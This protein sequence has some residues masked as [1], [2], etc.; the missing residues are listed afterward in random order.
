MASESSTTATSSTST[1]PAT[2]LWQ[3]LAYLLA[4]LAMNRAAR[5]IRER[6]DALA[7]IPVGDDAAMARH[8]EKTTAARTAA[9][10][11]LAGLNLAAPRDQ[12]AAHLTDA[13]TWSDSSPIARNAL[14]RLVAC[15]D[16]EFGIKIDPSGRTM[17]LDP[18][19]PGHEVQTAIEEDA[20]WLRHKSAAHAVTTLIAATS[21]SPPA[22]AEVTDIVN[23]W[24][25]TTPTNS[26][27]MDSAAL[28][29]EAITR[30]RDELAT[31][32]A[33]TALDE[34]DR[35][36]ALFM[37]DYLTDGHDHPRA[38]DLLDTPAVF[39][40]TIAPPPPRTAP[41]PEG[42]HRGPSPAPP[43]V[44]PYQDQSQG[45]TLNTATA[46]TSAQGGPSDSAAADPNSPPPHHDN[47]GDGGGTPDQRP[48]TGQP[49]AAGSQSTPP[50]AASA[51]PSAAPSDHLQPESTQSTAAVDRPELSKQLRKFADNVVALHQLAERFAD[52]PGLAL[53]TDMH[54]LVD[55]IQTQRE[56]LLAVAETGPGLA[57]VE[58]TQIRATLHDIESG[59][60]ELPTLLWIEEG[61]K[62]DTD[63]HRHL[64]R[65]RNIAAAAVSHVT[66][67]LDNA[68]L[69]TPVE[70]AAMA[71]LPATIREPLHN[72]MASLNDDSGPVEQRRDRYSTATVQLH[73]RL[74]DLGVD[75]D[76]RTKIGSFLRYDLAR[77]E[78][79]ER[80]ARVVREMTAL[81]DSTGVL[82]EPGKSPRPD[83]EAITASLHDLGQVIEAV[84]AGSGRR[85]RLL[86][87]YQ[88]ALNT[89]GRHLVDAG[90]DQSTRAVVRATID[91]HA[92]TAAAHA[93][94]GKD[95]RAR[96]AERATPVPDSAHGRPRAP[97]A[98]A[99]PL[100]STP[101]TDRRGASTYTSQQ[102]RQQFWRQRTH[103]RADSTRRSH[104]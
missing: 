104:A 75:E 56:Q 40:Q 99:E 88:K 92:K 77:A 95:R 63:E 62:R 14:D 34:H 23:A 31:A 35:L 46:A 57:P 59:K 82:I 49:P 78:P 72:I 2:G 97:S 7:R 84:A 65:G 79:A 19:F 6:Q 73:Q 15:F 41:S 4:A 16:R 70:P 81:L 9:E 21:L 58:R 53:T 96:W 5:Q 29:P 80:P 11:R 85:D 74:A 27:T 51:P 69:F 50:P 93:V 18:A 30:R 47:G 25:M 8:A 32:L 89:L 101:P 33:G 103:R 100:S 55:R 90:A 42:E 38:V 83:R 1:G 44:D 91:N 64:A 87:D 37:V 61:A 13:L 94:T 43:S 12:L 86:D 52:N 3:R 54:T 24:A 71:R 28:T 45:P 102:R 36:D 60:T 26:A 20:T 48:A 67:T 76:T 98:V 39:T 10:T 68:E 17:T 22:Q 66:E